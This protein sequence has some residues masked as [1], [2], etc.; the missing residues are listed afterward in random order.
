MGVEMILGRLL[1]REVR[2]VLVGK[3]GRDGGLIV[4]DVESRQDRDGCQC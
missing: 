3:V 1:I 2:T 4:G